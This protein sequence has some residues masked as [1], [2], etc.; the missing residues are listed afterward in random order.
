MSALAEVLQ[1]TEVATTF[2][3][4]VDSVAG[5]VSAVAHVPPA[6]TVTVWPWLT[7]EDGKPGVGTFTNL[8]PMTE[9]GLP[10]PET[11]IESPGLADPS[12]STTPEG[13]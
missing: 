13:V 10:L 9:P 1:A 6:A 7:V 4:P 5:S 11:V 12:L 8:R 2:Q 3:L